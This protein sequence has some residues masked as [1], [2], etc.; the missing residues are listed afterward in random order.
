MPPKQRDDVIWHLWNDL[1]LYLEFEMFLSLWVIVSKVI[2]SCIC[3]K[4]LQIDKKIFNEWLGIKLGEFFWFQQFLAI[5]Y[6]LATCSKSSISFKDSFQD[7]YIMSFTHQ[8]ST[9]R[10][11]P[12][13]LVSQGITP[14]I[15]YIYANRPSFIC[16]HLI[17]F[18][19]LTIVII[20]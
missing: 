17:K 7:V 14:A 18:Y 2:F 10:W 20:I 16:I 6:L 13:S 8:K 12:Y 15:S 11:C 5:K 4:C 3:L 1:L 9:A 19:F